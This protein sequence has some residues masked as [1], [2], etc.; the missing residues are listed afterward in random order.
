MPGHTIPHTSVLISFEEDRRLYLVG[1][2]VE[3]RENCSI[4]CETLTKVYELEEKI[5]KS[6]ITNKKFSQVQPMCVA[7]LVFPRYNHTASSIRVP[8]PAN[9]AELLLYIIVCGGS[10]P[11]SQKKVELIS[12]KTP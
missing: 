1:G 6:Y 8:K 7:N 4:E 5:I 3:Y 10:H 9:K 11:E 2:G 12:L